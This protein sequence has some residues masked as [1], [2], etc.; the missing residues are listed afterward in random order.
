MPL[1]TMNSN[2]N[3]YKGEVDFAALALQSADFLKQYN[4]AIILSFE[5]F[6]TDLLEV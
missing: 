2:R 3:I 6:I 4:P 5:K 1:S